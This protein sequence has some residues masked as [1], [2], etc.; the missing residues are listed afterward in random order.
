[1]NDAEYNYLFTNNDT[2]ITISEEAKDLIK[3][4]L[5]RDINKRINAAEAI[6]HN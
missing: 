2:E 5:C 1:M 6:N 3:K 4:L